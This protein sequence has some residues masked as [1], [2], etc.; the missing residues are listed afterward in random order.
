MGDVEDR[1]D[2][3]RMSRIRQSVVGALL[4]GAVLLIG[5]AFG[6]EP[7]GGKPAPATAQPTSLATSRPGAI[8]V[9]SQSD[10][11]RAKAA[12]Q[13]TER[14]RA[15]E[16]RPYEPPPGPVVDQPRVGGRR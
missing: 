3:I 6:C 8:D 16:R 7:G 14:E 4:C 11:D 1:P 15:A 10:T 12:I 9:I 13:R 5:V 2:R